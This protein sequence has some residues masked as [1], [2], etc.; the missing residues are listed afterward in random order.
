MVNTET[1]TG[2]SHLKNCTKGYSLRVE[3]RHFRH[4][5]RKGFFTVR[6]VKLYSALTHA[7]FR[8]YDK[9][10]MLMIND[11]KIHRN[12]ALMD[13]SYIWESYL[14]WTCW[15]C[16]AS[17]FHLCNVLLL[18]MSENTLHFVSFCYGALWI[19]T[20]Y[21]LTTSCVCFFLYSYRK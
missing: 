5:N 9:C 17:S 12:L 21:L 13:I 16:T 19:S 3:K 2:F 14:G 15:T 8:H 4:Q 7:P 6:V 18:F 20:G 10:V 11:I 1:I